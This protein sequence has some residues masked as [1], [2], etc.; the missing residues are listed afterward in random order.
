MRGTAGLVLGCLSLLLV[1]YPLAVPTR[2]LPV[3]LKG[4]EPAYYLAALSLARD[5]DLL[6]ETRDLHRLFDGFPH[7]PVDNLI[8]MSVDGWQTVHFGKP[9]IYSVLAAPFA[10]LFESR[11]MVAFNMALFMGMVWM[12]FF[13]LR[14]TNSE[15]LAAFFS[16][17]F[18]L[19]SV[20]F[21]YVFW[22]HTEI[23][24]MFSVMA[25]LYLAATEEDRAG[26]KALVRFFGGWARPLW[27]GAAFTGVARG[28]IPACL[29]R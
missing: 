14:R 6:C 12:G 15:G 3:T 11:G 10:A 19:I 28:L 9:I 25:C 7:L 16:A 20:G 5:G 17:S 21:A 29:R 24:N 23:L 22:L 13:Y 8:L 27:S 4:D 18:F 26:P 1:L 2:G